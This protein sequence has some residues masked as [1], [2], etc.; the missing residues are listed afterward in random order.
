MDLESA[1]VSNK[2]RFLESVHEEIHTRP[3]R[4]DHFRRRLLRHIRERPFRVGFLAV[5][6]QQEQRSCQP[7]LAGIKELIDQ[8]LFDS[9]ISGEH[10]GYEAVGKRMLSVKHALHLILFNHKHGRRHDRRGRP[11]PNSLACQAPFAKKVSR[12]QDCHN[13]LFAGFIG[14]AD[15]DAASLNVHHARRGIAL[16]VDLL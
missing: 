13:R 10:V 2:A 1:I 12:A 7:F 3:C 11:P 14:D 15:L 8:I 16:R 9:N 5:A 6:R 4:S